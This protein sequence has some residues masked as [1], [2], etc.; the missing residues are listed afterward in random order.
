VLRRGMPSEQL[1]RVVKERNI[2]LVIVSTRG[3][4][5]LR[6][7]MLGSVAEDVVRSS[8]CPVL[9]VG[10]HVA[11]KFENLSRIDNILF[12]TDFSEESLIVFPYLASLAHEYSSRLTVLH[13]LPV[14]TAGNP[15]AQA[16][17]EPLRKRMEATL[18]YQI[19]PQC[20]SD[21]V[22]ASGDP[23]KTILTYARCTNAD[24]IG[25]G[26]RCATDLA[27]RFSETVAYRILAEAE[28]PV[29][30]HH[31]ANAW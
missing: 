21:F 4:T 1:Q 24:L 29:L 22:I 3:R 23:A 25:L 9:T 17:A 18:G 6:H 30:T 13:V 27:K 16:L 11:R 12:P 20:Q 7:R 10:P 15:D 8:S 26:I 2:D 19:S 31:A 5:G 28:C 14:E